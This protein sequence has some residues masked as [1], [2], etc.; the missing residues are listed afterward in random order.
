MCGWGGA[1]ES[2]PNWGGSS[3]F[4]GLLQS[5]HSDTWG[6]ATEISFLLTF[7][8]L[9]ATFLTLAGPLVWLSLVL[10]PTLLLADSFVYNFPLF[11]LSYGLILLLFL[12][13]AFC[14]G[15]ERTCIFRLPCPAGSQNSAFA[16]GIQYL[17]IL[18]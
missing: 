3:A 4:S 1:W 16:L 7:S 2:Y 14:W 10:L 8:P 17:E 18:S 15:F 13:L 9:R 6:S 5:P 12:F 11:L